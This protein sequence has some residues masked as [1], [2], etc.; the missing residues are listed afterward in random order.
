MAKRGSTT[1]S[2]SE[3]QTVD[4]NTEASTEAQDNETNPAVEAGTAEGGHTFNV[5]DSASVI[6]GKLRGRKGQVIA[7][8]EG[9]KTYAVKL[10]DGTLAVLNAGNL[11]A[12]VDSTVSVRAL[13]EVL[14]TFGGQAGSPDEDAAIRLANALDTAIPGVSVKLHEALSAR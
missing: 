14:A 8:N 10:E 12:P 6:R 5:G 11:K 4:Q 9:D 1:Q 7:F 2:E 13:V 3:T